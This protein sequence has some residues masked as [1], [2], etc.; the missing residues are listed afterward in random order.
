MKDIDKILSGSDK[1]KSAISDV[2][3]KI[4]SI[5][6]EV[7]DNKNVSDTCDNIIDTNKKIIRE[8]SNGNDLVKKLEDRKNEYRQ[9]Y[10]SNKDAYDELKPKFEKLSDE[11]D[12][13]EKVIKDFKKQIKINIDVIEKLKKENENPKKEIENLKNENEKLKERNK[14]LESANGSLEYSLMSAQKTREEFGETIRKLSQEVYDLKNELNR[15]NKEIQRINDELEAAKEPPPIKVSVIIVKG[16]KYLLNKQTN[17]VYDYDIFKANEEEVII[18]KYDPEKNKIISDESSES[19]TNDDEEEEPAKVVRRITVEGKKYLVDKQ[20]NE[21][22]DYDIYK[23]NKEQV[24][25]GKY[26]P[27]KNKVTMKK[28]SKK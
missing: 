9:G 19:E 12:K 16:K 3:D 8:L 11:N 2:N 26:D 25:I 23:A 13:R 14:K 24:I 22:Y 5:K 4:L 6:R 20:T 18:G 15:K 27:K 7:E 1:I 10:E 17:D 21:V 28:S